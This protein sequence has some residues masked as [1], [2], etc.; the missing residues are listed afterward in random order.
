MPTCTLPRTQ[1]LT[2]AHACTHTHTHTHTQCQSVQ[3][4]YTNKLRGSDHCRSGLPISR[5]SLHL[6]EECQEVIPQLNSVVPVL[7][8]SSKDLF[9][10]PFI[11]PRTSSRRA[12]PRMSRRGPS[13]TG[14][15]RN[16]SGG[17]APNPSPCS[18]IP[19][20]TPRMRRRRLREEKCFH[21]I[22]SFV[23]SFRHWMVNVHCS[24]IH[25]RQEVNTT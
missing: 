22:H 2:R 15:R 23:R 14:G 12:P 17:L 24:T 11:M 18:A 25:S 5:T 21:F 13:R 4:S 8:V 7:S 19:A 6:F 1:I 10:D 16:L 3:S 9:R 20:P